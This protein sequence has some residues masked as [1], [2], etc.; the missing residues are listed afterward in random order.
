V[1]VPGLGGD[2]KESALDFIAEKGITFPVVFDEGGH[3]YQQYEVRGV[4]NTIF[5]DRNGVI[6]S[7]YPGAMEAEQLEDQIRQLL[8]A[9]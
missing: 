5:V 6:V 9:G 1:N 3:V 8:E 2:T 7:N 4:P